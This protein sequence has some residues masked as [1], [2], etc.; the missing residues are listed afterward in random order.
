M[1]EILQFPRRLDVFDAETTKAMGDAFDKAIASL[2]DGAEWEP[3]VRELVAKRIIKMARRGENDRV[4]LCTLALSGWGV[5]PLPPSIA[6]GL[7]RF[8]VR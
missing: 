1:A 6:D 8:F 7:P 5:F 3:I 4:R 2:H